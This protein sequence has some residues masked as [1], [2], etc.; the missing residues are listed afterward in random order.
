MAYSFGGDRRGNVYD[1]YSQDVW[2]PFEGFPYV[3][4]VA[5][6]PAASREASAP[7]NIRIDWK[8]TPQAHIIKADLPGLRKDELKIE[9][10]ESR[11]LQISG[12]RTK[13]HEDKYD[14]W[15]RVERVTGKFLR[16]LKL[17][18]NTK[19]E[20]VKAGKDN[21]VLT[22]V[23]PKGQERKREVKCIDISG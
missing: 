21:G 11:L 20:Q 2:D 18:E 23:V 17:P 12:E 13:E 8:E 10:D 16:R 14:K 1:P 9:V 15:H 4:T 7:A 5:N 6:A 19:I 3:S 22:V